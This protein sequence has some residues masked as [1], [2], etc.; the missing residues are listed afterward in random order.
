MKIAAQIERDMIQ[1]GR[2]RKEATVR[3]GALK[4]STNSCALKDSANSCALKDS[5]APTDAAKV[6]T[7]AEGR[8]ESHHKLT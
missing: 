2:T 1:L 6:A 4:D 8:L 5:C 3:D 7:S